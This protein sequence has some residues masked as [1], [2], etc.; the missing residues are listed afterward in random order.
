MIT[1]ITI[2]SI[3]LLLILILTHFADLIREDLWR[4]YDLTDEVSKRIQNSKTEIQAREIVEEIR[5]QNASTLGNARMTASVT[6]GKIYYSV[7][8]SRLAVL[9]RFV[10]GT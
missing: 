8:S 3:V 5:E 4:E 9:K 1:I 2:L 10:T 6:S 7:N